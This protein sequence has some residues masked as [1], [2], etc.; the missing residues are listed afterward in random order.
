LKRGETFDTCKRLGFSYFQ[1]YHFSR[2]EVVQRRELPVEMVRIASL[3]NLAVHESN[4][5]RLMEREVRSDP[6]LSFKLLRIINAAAQGGRGVVSILHAI[7]VVGRTS[8]HRWLAL[9]FVGATPHASDVDRELILLTLERGRFCELIA[10]E[11][12]NTSAA[13]ALF[14]AGLLSSFDTVLG[15]PMEKLLQQIRVGDDVAA[16]LLGN[17]GPYT[18]YLKLATAYA[19]ADWDIVLIVGRKA[20]NRRTPAAALWRSGYV[21]AESTGRGVAS[22]FRDG[23][24]GSV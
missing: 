14:L 4:S 9:L 6:G 18:P 19:A 20:R 16:A 2:P 5:D 17:D 13:G 1:G 3:M 23:A 8:L 11:A 12:G 21:G 24:K 10:M 22:V 7:R 15:V